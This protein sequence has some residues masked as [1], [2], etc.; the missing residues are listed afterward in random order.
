MGFYYFTKST[1]FKVIYIYIYINIYKIN[2]IN[3]ILFPLNT[4]TPLCYQRTI[5][6]Q[7]DF[8]Q[9]ILQT[10]NKMH[11]HFSIFDALEFTQSY[12]NM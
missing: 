11:A 8:F 1:T 10:R 2:I 3:W 9:L 5:Q 4:F 7:L 6:A 12:R